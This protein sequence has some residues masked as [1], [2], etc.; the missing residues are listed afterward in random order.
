MAPILAARERA[1]DIVSRTV[2]QDS[3]IST[4]FICGP[5]YGLQPKAENI[6]QSDPVHDT[7]SIVF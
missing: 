2:N 7:S 5:D 1:T 4:R 6:A 3:Q